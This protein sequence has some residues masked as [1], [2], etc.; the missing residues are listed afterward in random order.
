M[1]MTKTAYTIDQSFKIHKHGKL[2]AHGF[3]DMESA[4]HA[5]F[6]MEGK[7]PG[8]FFVEVNGEVFKQEKL[9]ERV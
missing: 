8:T 2:E 5:V 4:L 1:L 7:V 9:N 6:K 3:Q